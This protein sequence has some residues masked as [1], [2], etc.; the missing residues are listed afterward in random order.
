[1]F[2]S[3]DWAYQSGTPNRTTL[4]RQCS[5]SNPQILDLPEN[6]DIYKHSSLFCRVVGD[7]QKKFCSYNG[8]LN[9]NFSGIKK[10]VDECSC[11]S[12]FALHFKNQKPKAIKHFV[13]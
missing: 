11:G 7:V 10:S 4:Y 3:K 1:M 6:I 9:E 13:A 8:W 2:K 5:L 12:L